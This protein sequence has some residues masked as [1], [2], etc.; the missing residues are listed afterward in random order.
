MAEGKQAR[1][2]QQ[3][4]EGAGEQRKTH[5]LHQQHGV[6]QQRR[7]QQD[8]PRGQ[9]GQKL[10]VFHLFAPNRPAGRTI[11]TTTMVMNTTV[12]LNSGQYT[13]TSPSSTPSIRPVNTEPRMEPMPPITTTANTVMIRLEP[14]SG[15][16]WVVGAASTPAKAASATP[17]P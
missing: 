12:A 15:P 3:Q 2:T 8:G 6:D 17:K 10:R 1:E 14:M 7:Q 16:V 9:P 13:L 4:I 11:S 5:D